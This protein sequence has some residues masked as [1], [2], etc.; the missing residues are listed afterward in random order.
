MPTPRSAAEM[1]AARSVD[2]HAG[3]RRPSNLDDIVLAAMRENLG[4]L[5][6]LA[7]PV[8]SELVPD[9]IALGRRNEGD[10]PGVETNLVIIDEA[11]VLAEVL[12]VDVSHLAFF[13]HV[14]RR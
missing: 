4:D 10:S 5:N 3:S 8:V 6:A 11:L 2:E 9:L 7:A 14:I 1:E 12:I 13:Q